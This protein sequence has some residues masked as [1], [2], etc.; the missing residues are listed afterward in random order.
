[1]TSTLPIFF[2]HGCRSGSTLLQS[3]LAQNPSNH[4]TSTNDLSL[5]LANAQN[6]WTGMEGFRAQGLE[7]LVTRMR[8]L[9][10]GM[11][12]GFYAPEFASGKAV[13][14]K[15]RDWLSR[16]ELIEEVLEQ[17]ARIILTIR[18]I[19]DTVASLEKLFR[20]NQITKPSRTPEQ[21][22]N[23]QTVKD[24]CVQYLASDAMLGMTINAIKDCFEKGLDDRLIIVP[25]HCLVSD[26]VGTI[27]RIHADCGLPD[28][29][30]DPSRVENK[31][32]ENDEVH[33]RPFHTLRDSVDA[34]A[35]GQWQ[36]Y[37]PEDVGAWLCDEYPSI[38]DLCHGNYRSCSNA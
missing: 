23:G 17:P 29:I 12:E 1:M 4:C 33:G 36:K 11:I 8:G 13:F 14:D 35:I 21:Q 3:L 16:I 18:D 31:A 9:M 34:S 10:R 38:Q 22:I 37:L 32:V 20:E 7:S 2:V 24:R 26:P 19:R 25:Y 30:C 5:L 6:Q 15:S 28:F 27:S